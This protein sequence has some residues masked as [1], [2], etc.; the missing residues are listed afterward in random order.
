[1]VIKPNRSASRSAEYI[2]LPDP[3]P[4][5]DM[6]N[7]NHLARNGNG[8][9]LAQ[10]LG[11]QETTLIISEIYISAEPTR[12]RRGLMAPDLLIAF[13]VKPEV[14]DQRRGYVI[15]DHGKP[16]DFVLEI[17]SPSTAHRDVT[18]KRDGYAA[19]GIPEY[20]RFDDSG[21]DY[22][23]V[24]IAGDRLVSGRYEPIN[25]DRIDAQ[26]YQGYSPT[27]DLNL[28]WSN[29][30]LG[31]HNPTTGLHIPT[32]DDERA[33]RIQAEQDREQERQARIQAETQ[34]REIEEQIRQMKN[35]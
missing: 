31:W 20:W 18:D 32:F 27:L 12:E 19:L 35:E 11:R 30:A 34:L 4:Q 24:P 6:T 2:Q 8:H 25:I 7:Y 17:A 10:Y 3:P 22:H 15:S 1:M 5:E 16:P 33:A 26:T 23:G 14:V 9:H 13:N 21:G 29:G 28:R